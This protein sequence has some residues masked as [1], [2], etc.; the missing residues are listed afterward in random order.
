MDG[1]FF[2]MKGILTA[3]KE[4]E[5]EEEKDALKDRFLY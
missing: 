4:E 5:E 1:L 2:S 3:S